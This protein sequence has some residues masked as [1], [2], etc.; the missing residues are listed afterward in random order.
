[1]RSPG[2]LRN[3]R[4]AGRP[5]GA[6]AVA[7]ALCLTCLPQLGAIDFHPDLR[8]LRERHPDDPRPRV[9]VFGSQSCG[10]CRK[11]AADTLASPLV[12]AIADQCLWL[13]VDV[14]EQE[15]LAAQY[16]V[17]G[18]PHIVIA[19]AN[20]HVMAERP[21]YLPAAE[22]VTFLTEAL[23][24]PAPTAARLHELL[25]QVASTGDLAQRRTAVRDL[26]DQIARVDATGRDQ[27]IAAMEQLDAG[28]WAEFVPYL[29]HPRL[30]MRAAAHGLL[31]RGSPAALPF[32]PFASVEERA[33]Q[34]LAWSDWMTERGADVPSLELPPPP[35][36]SSEWTPDSTDRPPPP[37]LPIL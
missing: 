4:R 22:F 9:I 32:D 29:S 5:V 6:L 21:G 11:L 36:E 23:Q 8:S 25:A 34:A 28:G 10:W 18:L 19:D 27:A 1:M 17:R 7:A 3:R 12:E 13:K 33:P 24:N 26:L 30:S 37:P 20:G 16:G 2:A 15:A 31:M 35:V 14:D